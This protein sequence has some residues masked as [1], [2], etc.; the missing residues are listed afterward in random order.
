MAVAAALDGKI[1]PGV[2]TAPADPAMIEH[3]FA[4]LAEH[5]DPVHWRDHL[6][7]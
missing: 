6:A 4:T 1:S 3:W 7:G 5:G 2:S